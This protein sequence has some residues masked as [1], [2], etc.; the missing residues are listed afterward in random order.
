MLLSWPILN[1][2]KAK[3]AKALRNL[4][5]EQATLTRFDNELKDLE[6]TIKA[7]KAAISDAELQLKQLEHDI[8]Q[9]GKDRTSALHA[10]ENL[11][12]QY[13]WIEDEQ[14]YVASSLVGIMV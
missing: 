12:K 3:H 13:D 4:Q 2:G 6:G 10:V 1:V 8:Q 11:E 14:E 5:D 9:L 7:K